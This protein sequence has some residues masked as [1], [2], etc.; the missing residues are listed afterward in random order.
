V[1][2]GIFTY[3]GAQVQ[4]WGPVMATATL[5]AIPAIVLL[6]IAQ[7]YIA[8]GATGGAVK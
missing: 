7:K 2:L 5:S 4:N 8:A 3:L 1:T 6:V